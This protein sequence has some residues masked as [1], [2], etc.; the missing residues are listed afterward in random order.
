MLYTL[1]RY[2]GRRRRFGCGEERSLPG[3]LSGFT[4]VVRISFV[5]HSSEPAGGERIEWS[6]DRRA[7]WDKVGISLRDV[8]ARASWC[9]Q[10]WR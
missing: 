10:G 7:G 8:V 6:S 1:G 2:L 3:R 4:V 9:I 5:V